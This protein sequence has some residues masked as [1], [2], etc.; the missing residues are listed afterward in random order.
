MFL[1][2]TSSELSSPESEFSKIVWIS[3]DSFDPGSSTISSSPSA[4]GSN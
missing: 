4:G 3:S 1:L 2:V